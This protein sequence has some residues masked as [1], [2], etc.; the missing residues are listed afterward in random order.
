[1]FSDD[2]EIYKKNT[3]N[4]RREHRLFD[5]VSRLLPFTTETDYI[6]ADSLLLSELCLSFDVYPSL[7]WLQFV[8]DAF[9]SKLRRH[10]THHTTETGGNCLERV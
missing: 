2:E 4:E 1:M 6:T 9:F 8:R 7:L 10:V 3:M 5:Q